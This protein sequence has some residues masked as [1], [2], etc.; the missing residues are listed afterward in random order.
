MFIIKPVYATC[1]V[2]IITVGGGLIIAKKLGIDDLLVSIWIGGLNTAIAF[3]FSSMIKNKIL[4]NA[5]LLSSIFYFLTLIY[6]WYTKQLFHP[7]N[8]LWGIDKVILGITAGFLVFIISV[9]IDKQI[10]LKNKRKVL[11]YYQKVVIPFIM[12]LGVTLF[13]KFF[14]K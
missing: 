7:Q 12:L 2:C 13:F 3:W 8:T 10:R 6:L 14:I 11:F 5:Y 1:P 4:K 9:L